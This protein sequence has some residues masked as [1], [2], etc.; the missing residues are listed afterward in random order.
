MTNAISPYQETI[1]RRL[2]TLRRTEVDPRH[3]EAW[4]RVAHPTLDGLSSVQFDYEVLIAVGCL[5]AWPPKDND[6]LAETFGL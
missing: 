6:R 1:K 4:M 5:D 3:V 2:L